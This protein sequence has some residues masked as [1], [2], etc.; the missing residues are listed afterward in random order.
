MVTNRSLQQ[1][2]GPLSA[3]HV[4]QMVRDQMVSSRADIARATGLARST[5]SQRVEVLLEL[6]LLIEEEESS[7]TGGRPP[8]RLR[9]NSQGGVVLAADLGATHVSI[10]ITDLEGRVLAS[11]ST[12][13]RIAEGPE[14]VLGW[15]TQHF[16]NLL[17]ETGR[18]ADEVRGIGI[19]VPGPVEFA[20]GRVVNPPIMPGWDGYAIPE[21]F[22]STYPLVPVLV[23]NDVNIM[24]IGEYWSQWRNSVENLVY[25]KVATGIGAGIIAGGHIYRGAQGAA[26]DIGHVQVTDRRRDTDDARYLQECTCGNVGCVEAV[27]SGTALARDLTGKGFEA[28]TTRDVVALVKAGNLEAIRQVREAGRDIGSVLAHLVNFLN[29]AVVVI[30]GDLSNAQEPL[31]A[32]I[33]EVVY[34]RSTALATGHLQMMKS[35]L[36]DA[37]GVTGAAVMVLEQCLSPEAVDRQIFE[38]SA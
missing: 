32:G 10:A 11:E 9:F 29:P 8:T 19:G 18:S 14:T 31:F 4:L 17:H 36:G 24:A 22:H 12:E 6:G 15:V 5:V 35:R 28:R 25:V 2:G 30:G 1:L 27:A 34:R 20:H 37:A 3:G 23:D 21:A 33:R 13:L 16:E 7:S 38:V 26:G